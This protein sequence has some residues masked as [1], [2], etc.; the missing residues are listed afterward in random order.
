MQLST[1]FQIYRGS[2]FY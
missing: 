2:K 1:V